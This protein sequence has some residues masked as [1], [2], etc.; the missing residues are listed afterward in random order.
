MREDGRTDKKLIVAF[1]NFGLIIET[2][3]P[4]QAE[5]SLSFRGPKSV[6]PPA[7]IV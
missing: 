3:F 4:I 5:Y 6:Y 7:Y 1:R 2:S